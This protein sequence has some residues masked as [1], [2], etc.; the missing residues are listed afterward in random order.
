MAASRSTRRLRL[1][2]VLLTTVLALVAVSAR[3]HATTLA[4]EVL[5][6]AGLT[7]IIVATL[8]RLWASLFI[9]GFKDDTLVR[10]GP[11]SALRHPLY[12]LSWVAMLGIGLVTR[13]IAI[14]LALAV[15]FAVVYW[16]AA[17]GED[18]VLLAAHGV[19]FERYRAA[20]P[21]VVPRASDYGVPETLE[22]RPRVLWKAFLDAGSVFGFYALLQLADALQRAGVTPTWLTLP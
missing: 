16:S 18:A 8:G 20:T 5:E 12:A 19:T 9:A 21:A 13:S 22:V 17:R 3:P 10:S 15:I 14:T 7:C 11:Y 2:I 4:G 6:L 1:T